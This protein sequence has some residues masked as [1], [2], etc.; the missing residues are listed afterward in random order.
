MKARIVLLLAALALAA[1]V[2][3]IGMAEATPPMGIGSELLAR[4]TTADEHLLGIRGTMPNRLARAWRGTYKTPWDVTALRVTV[5]PGAHSGWHRHPGPGFMVVTQGAV[6]HYANDC[7]K[8]T[9]SRGQAF[10]EVPGLVNLLR[11]DGTEPAVMVGAFVVPS[12]ASLRIDVP[13]EP[14]KA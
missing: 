4:G 6:T 1:P 9:Y 13:M 14:C 12:T 7:S 2:A 11:N 5:P 10:M 8:K 3:V